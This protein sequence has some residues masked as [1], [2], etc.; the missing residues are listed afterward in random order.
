MTVK[1]VLE[2][3]GGFLGGIVCWMAHDGKHYG[4]CE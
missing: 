3:C 1:D 2:M 4:A